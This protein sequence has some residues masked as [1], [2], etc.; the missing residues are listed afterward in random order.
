MYIL[1]IGIIGTPNSGKSSLINY[2]TGSNFIVSHRPHST[3]EI[4]LSIFCKNFSYFTE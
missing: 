2:I 4:I 1:K 3:K